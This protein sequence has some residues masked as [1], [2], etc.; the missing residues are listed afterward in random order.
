MVRIS[1]FHCCGQ[2]IAQSRELTSCKPQDMTKKNTFVCFFN[3]NKNILKERRRSKQSSLDPVKIVSAHIRLGKRNLTLPFQE[4]DHNVLKYRIIEK[5]NIYYINF[6]LKW[7]T[8]FLKASI[9]NDILF[10]AL[11][12]Y[13]IFLHIN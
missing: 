6:L 12:F 13:F 1:G 2:F 8:G 7:K 9:Y 10:L 5:K 11:T 3:K 4:T